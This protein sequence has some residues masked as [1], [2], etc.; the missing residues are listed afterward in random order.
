MIK[1]VKVG[2]IEFS[3]FGPNLTEGL[4]PSIFYFALSAKDSL[5]ID[6]YNQPI[7]FIDNQKFRI[8]SCDLPEHEADKSP[9]DAIGKWIEKLSK[10]DDLLTCFFDKLFDAFHLLKDKGQIDFN[11]IA[12]MGLSRGAFVATHIASR[13]TES[14]P[15][16]G[17]SPLTL[18][19]EVK[20][21]KEYGWGSNHLDLPSLYSKLFN[22]QIRF[23]I[24]NRDTRVS[25]K[26]CAHFILEL[27]DRAYDAGFKS[28]PI[29]LKIF[30]SIGYMGHGTPK[31]IFQD[32]ASFI[33]AL[34]KNE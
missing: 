21:S 26:N 1:Q 15:I 14:I 4:L 11:K 10:G 34:L 23:Y 32:G 17:F 18:L 3:Y 29:E 33:T 5:T 27:A 8:F 16:V 31:T 28:A 12:F 19:S 13:F 30:P 22:K 9:Y 24:G 25:S 6:P 20:E 7:S 2:E